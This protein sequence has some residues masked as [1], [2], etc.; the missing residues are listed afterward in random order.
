VDVQKYPVRNTHRAHLAPSDLLPLARTSFET[1]EI[2]GAAVVARFGAIVRLAAQ[3]EGKELLIDVT[4]DPKVPE[5]VAADTI[6]RYNQFLADATGFSAKERA[7][8]LR[9]SPGG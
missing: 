5:A 4:M 8:R 2:E 3:A 1:A 9:K 7:K 6:K